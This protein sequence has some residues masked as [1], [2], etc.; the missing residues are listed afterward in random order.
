[1][2]NISKKSNADSKQSLA[3]ICG[4]FKNKSEYNLTKEQVDYISNDIKANDKKFVCINTLSRLVFVILVDDK[5]NHYTMLESIRK[6]GA[7][8]SDTINSEKRTSVCCVNELANTDYSFPADQYSGCI[9]V[10]MVLLLQVLP[11]PA[12]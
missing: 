8:I 1:M 12:Q 6:N 7:S 5:K 3:I 11:Y 9:I 4:A 2:T 10:L